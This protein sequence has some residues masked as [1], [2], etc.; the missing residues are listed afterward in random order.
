MA[1]APENTQVSNTRSRRRPRGS[2][3]FAFCNALMMTRPQVRKI[4]VTLRQSTNPTAQVWKMKT[5]LDGTRRQPRQKRLSKNPKTIICGSRIEAQNTLAWDKSNCQTASK[6]K[7]FYTPCTGWEGP[8][9]NVHPERRVKSMI[10][11]SKWGYHSAITTL[12]GRILLSTF[13]TS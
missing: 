8:P 1:T 10:F 11:Q 3:R 5:L 4:V 7:C 9:T 12:M 13:R 2:K 6:W